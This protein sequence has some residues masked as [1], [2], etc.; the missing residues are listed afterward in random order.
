[1]GGWKPGGWASRGGLVRLK[2]RLRDGPTMLAAVGGPAL[3]T[4]AGVLLGAAARR[5]PVLVDG[6]VGA[7]AALAA[8]DYAVPVRLWCLL[9]DDS[10]DPPVRVAP[11]RPGLA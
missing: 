8:R 1:G 11:D 7:A 9:T 5:T 6:P 3:A 10:T 2:P 4:A